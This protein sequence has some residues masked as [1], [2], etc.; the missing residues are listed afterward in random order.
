MKIISQKELGYM[1]NGT[2]FSKIVDP[3]FYRGVNGDMD[4]NGL[5][6]ICGH[7]ENDDYSS[8]ESGHFHACVHMLEYVSQQNKVCKNEDYNED[9][10]FD[11]IDTCEYD[12]DKDRY[13]VI[14]SQ[15]D[16][17]AI[18]RNLEWALRGCEGEQ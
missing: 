12:Y 14:Y 2:V 15:D 13:F 5:S 4:I 9:Y 1:P 3:N 6:I 8:S 10:W 16:I 11:S 17:K 18:I 7:D